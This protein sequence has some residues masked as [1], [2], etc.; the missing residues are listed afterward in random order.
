MINY[1][2]QGMML[3][4]Q[5]RMQ[6]KALNLEIMTKHI[7]NI[8]LRRFMKESDYMRRIMSEW[9]TVKDKEITTEFVDAI[10]DIEKEVLGL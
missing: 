5:V 10:T 8:V 6:S 2:K 7:R 9:Y 4:V 1:L 3:V